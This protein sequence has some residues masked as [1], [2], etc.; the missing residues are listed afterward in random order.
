MKRLPYL[1]SLLAV[2]LLPNS[3][4]YADELESI[5]DLSLKDLLNVKVSVASTKPESVIETPAIVSRYNRVDLEKMGVT[6]LREMFNFIPGVIVQYSMPGWATVQIRGVDEAFNQKVLFLLDGV[7]YHQPSH[8]MIPMEGVPWESIS[9]VEVIRGPGA[10]FYGSQA[11]GGVFNV[12]TKKGAAASSASIKAGANGLL[13]GSGYYNKVI[14]DESSL[15]VAGE[16][17]TEDG[18]TTTYN[19]LIPDVSVVTDDVHKYL[20]RQ[21]AII[22]YNHSDFILQLQAFSDATIGMNDAYTN[23]NTLQPTTMETKGQLIHLENSWRT[24]STKTTLFADYNHYTF[25]L[26]INNLF[27]P[28][29]HALATKDGNGTKD[30]RLRYGGSL[31]YNLNDDLDVVA[32]LEHE[33]RSIDDYRIYMLDNLAT[34]LVTLLEKGKVDEFSAYTQLDYSYQNWRFLVGGRYT[35]NERSGDKVTPRAAAVYKLDEHQ[36][37][38]FIQQALTHP[39]LRKLVFALLLI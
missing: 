2:F 36:S 1:T 37:K 33:T 18:Y 17:R 19:E 29:V 7:P 16:Y 11:S 9:H 32:G 10:V 24:K 28:D 34:P 27:A 31:S 15:Y 14:S 22:R 23:E 21:S 26:Q 30:Y 6:T 12:I 13:E 35:D 39:T 3:F 8:S 20:E 4:A 5:F 38:R 25:D